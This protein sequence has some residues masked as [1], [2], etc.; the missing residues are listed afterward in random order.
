MAKREAKGLVD[1]QQTN[2]KPKKMEIALDITSLTEV[3]ASHILEHVY[4]DPSIKIPPAAHFGPLARKVHDHY[5]V[6]EQH[7]KCH[8]TR[9]KLSSSN[10]S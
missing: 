2:T 9:K 3:V 6:G 1:C 7:S 4:C 8:A 10:D 5:H